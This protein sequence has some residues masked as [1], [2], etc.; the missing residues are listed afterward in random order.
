MSKLNE[1][2]PRAADS[3]WM[4]LDT[5][6]LAGL[7]LLA[8]YFL[9][10]SWRKW[11]DPVIDFGR[12]LYL[13]WRLSQGAVLY[14]DVQDYY[15][16]LSQYFNAMLFKL[17]GIGFTTLVAANLTVYAAILALLY[18]LV[19]AGWGRLAATVSGAIFVAV[20]SF[21]HIGPIGNFNY[22]APYAHEATHG[23]LVTLLLVL[24]WLSAIER[25][26]RWKFFLAGVLAGLC[27]L[28]KPEFI[29]VAA[30][31]TGAAVWLLARE[32]ARQSR[33]GAAIYFVLGAI[34]PLLAAVALFRIFSGVPL[35]RA[36]EYANN[37]WVVML[38]LPGKMRDP[39]QQTFLGT[40]HLGANLLRQFLWSGFAVVIA[41]GVGWSCRRL[42]GS[43]DK[44]LYLF[45]A[46]VTA[47]GA[48]L[49]R[50]VD[51]TDMGAALVG[52]LAL[53]A[54][55]EVGRMAPSDRSAAADASTV[56]RV[57]LWTA[58]IAL[59]PRMA[60]NPRV[61]H[62]GFYQAPLAAA[63]GIATL[64][65][66]VPE[67]FGLAGTARKCYQ[68]LLVALILCGGGGVARVS[69]EWLAAHDLPIADG[70][71]R[72]YAI[73]AQLD[74]TG[75]LVETAR[76]YLAA[77]SSART[78]V[79]LPEGVM[80]NYLTRLPSP[81]PVYLFGP[82]IL[83]AETRR[84]LVKKLQAEPPDRVVFISRDMS[85]FG[86]ERFG[87]SPENGQ[88]LLEFVQDHY[89][90]VFRIGGDPLD[91]N[92]RGVIIAARRPAESPAPEER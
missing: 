60:F 13:P 79:V 45:A 84:A 40:K 42:S 5:A 11:P 24:A 91:V 85:D 7:G 78:I 73:N 33:S 90:P 74:P 35:L 31:V 28:L 37:A 27:L 52:L 92:Q 6:L 71:D 9:A 2:A 29:I 54:L 67:W 58:A 75:A 53:A 70:P 86:V 39:M 47:I 18:Y 83:T 88:E 50:V 49:V 8:L 34:V 46:G 32:P 56:A 63:V 62:F 82:A 21:S 23:V 17:A 80:L 68:M 12:E 66:A 65:A 64:V 15:G 89:Q 57:L 81:L 87:D 48:W 38:R 1:P 19:R 22:A 72:F 10:M 51:W 14:R 43:G 26:A 16:P 76:Q 55:L 36:L 30:A 41:G 61:N 20:F 4:P 3:R 59:L 77:D 25:C 44:L 69:V